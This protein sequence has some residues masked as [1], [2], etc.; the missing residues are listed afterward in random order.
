MMITCGRKCGDNMLATDPMSLLVVWTITGM[1]LGFFSTIYGAWRMQFRVWKSISHML[2]FLWF[3]LAA[4]AIFFVLFW[5]D[6][7][8][9]RF[10]SLVWMVIGYGLWAI[11]AGP[12]VLGVFSFIFHIFARGGFWALWPAQHVIHRVLALWRRRSPPPKPPQN[13]E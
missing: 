9:F 2:D 6:W 11:L 3:I 5:S 12:F 4:I 1:G 10:W 7:G 13:G 8:V